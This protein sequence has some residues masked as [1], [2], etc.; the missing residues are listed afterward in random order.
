MPGE[1][2]IFQVGSS[3][4]K[5]SMQKRIIQRNNSFGRIER[6]NKQCDGAEKLEQEVS[7]DEQKCCDRIPE[8]KDQSENGCSVSAGEDPGRKITGVNYSI[9]P[10]FFNNGSVA[11]FCKLEN[12]KET[13]ENENEEQ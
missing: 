13:G 11:V 6:E 3:V 5:C 7:A 8:T 12:E 10:V 4:I 1:K 9:E 2:K